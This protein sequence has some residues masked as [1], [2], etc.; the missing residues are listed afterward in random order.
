MNN[1]YKSGR[2]TGKWLGIVLC[3][4]VLVLVCTDTLCAATGQQLARINLSFEGAEIKSVLK[5]IKAQTEFDFIY[6]ARE[7]NDKSRVSVSLKD[8]DIQTALK[9]CFDQ[10]GVDFVIQDKIIVLQKKQGVAGIPQ[11]VR[12]LVGKV[13]DRSGN[14]LPG[15]SVMLKGTILGVATDMAGHFSFSIPQTDEVPELLFSFIGM[16]TESYK[17]TGDKEMRIVMEESSESLGEVVVTG[18]EVVKKERMT[19]SATVV[20]AK[21][22]KM[23]GIT[24]IDRILEGMVAG[25]NSTT[26]SGAPGTRSKITIRGENNLNGNTEPLWIIDGLPMMSGV[27]KS[28]TGDYAGT[29][30]QDGVGNVMPEDIESISILKDASAAAI[31][32][33]RAANGVII[34]TTKKGFRSKTQVNYSG[35]YEFGVAPKNNLDFMSAAEKL[36]YERSIIDNFGM[37]FADWTGQGGF[38]YKRRLGGYLTEESYNRELSR[39]S[40]YNT[41]WFDV[42]F[43]TAQSHSHN[44]SLR[45][46][47]DELTYYTSASFQQQN[48]IL[49]PNKYENAGILMK[50]DYRPIKNL[51]VALDIQANTRKNKNHASAIDPFKY[52]MFANRYERPFDDE[53]NYAP[54]LSYLSHNYTTQTGSGYVYDQFNIVKEMRDTKNT[55]LGLDAQVTFDI[56]YEVI[57]GL[58]LESIVRKGVSYNNETIEADAGTYTSWVNEKFGRSAYPGAAVLPDQYDNGELTENSGRNYN[59]SIRN[60]I[61]YSFNIKED[62]LFSILV[63]NEVMSKKFNN[64]GYTSPI[65]SADYRITG[66][67]TFN[68]DVL[69]EDVMEDV[70]GMFNTKDGQDRS[71]SFLGSLR[72]GYKDRYIFN[73][74]YRADGADVIGNTNRFTPLWSV[75][76]RYNLHKEKFFANKVISELS[77]RGSYGYTGNIDRSA[78][79]FSTISLG[80]GLYMGNRYVKGFTY[81]NPTVSWEKKQDRNI[82]LDMSLFDHRISFTVDY[83]SNRTEDILED[84]EVPASTGR[85]NV[86]ANGGVVEN[87]GLEFYLNIRWVNRRDFSFSTSVNL[88]RNKN[89]I[90]KSFY[91]YDSYL[92]AIRSDVI[93]GGKLN[94]NGAETGGI[95]G[96]KSAG[97][98]PKT[99]NPRYYLTEEGKRAYGSFLDAWDSYSDSKKKEYIGMI[100]DFNSVPEYVDYVRN[101]DEKM[102]Y[103]MPSMQYLGRSNPKYVGGFNTYMRYKGIE[104][105]TSWTFKTGHLIPNFNDYQNAPNN[106]NALQ[107]AIGYSSDLAVSATNREKKYLNYWQHPGDIT[108]VAG[109]VTVRNDY[110]AAVCT[111]DNYSKGDYLRMTNLSLS[112]RFPAHIINKMRMKNLSV[113]FNA[114]NLLTFTKYKGLDVGSGDAFTYPVSREFNFKVTVGF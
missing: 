90:K 29:I 68:T 57:P 113:G 2:L 89:V 74:N 81:P 36:R 33:A 14:P 54:D 3:I 44:I 49:L 21:D 96:W 43:R 85:T 6:N 7:I 59:W 9:A 91:G 104:F 38:L 94:I 39:L 80:S 1:R 5:E 52:A 45:G 13:V 19:G 65:Y 83:Y 78:Y 69:Y 86:K 110:W 40:S 11:Q 41:D 18:M 46:G 24:S 26:I 15:V 12:K 51:I 10:L 61:D 111:S 64:F 77:L 58:A 22:L 75:G 4:G 82:G 16:K 30:M 73:A 102:P 27:P 105:S 92:D 28:T 31:Y 70:A 35:T 114:R 20:T 67:P 32:G 107:A 23:Q 100:E 95:Y 99:G 66:V 88:A 93:Q 98:N 87:K 48:G 17:V 108:D 8:A 109:F 84:L 72:Y 62:H 79:P 112:Y 63:A 97:V 101:S 50:L 76:V 55:Q 56:R 25:L 42:L 106:K 71:V 53:G 60:Q 103:Y 34:I 47:N 37:G